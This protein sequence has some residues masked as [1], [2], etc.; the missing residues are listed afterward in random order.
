VYHQRTVV[1]MGSGTRMR[2]ADRRPWENQ[3]I[4]ARLVDI[5]N[6]IGTLA[7]HG[8]HSCST[9]TCLPRAKRGGPGEAPWWLVALTTS[10]QLERETLLIPT[11]PLILYLTFVYF[12]CSPLVE[13]E[14]LEGRDLVLFP[15]LSPVPRC[16]APNRP[17]SIG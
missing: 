17:L 5:G 12:F 16:L 15:P 4:W 7:V 2:V 10:G 13:S 11:P 14:S 3:G 8:T 6:V 1:E 9:A